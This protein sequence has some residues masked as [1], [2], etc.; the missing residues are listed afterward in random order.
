M[1]SLSAHIHIFLIL[2]R[3]ICLLLSV[4]VFFKWEFQGGMMNRRSVHHEGRLSPCEWICSVLQQIIT[5]R[6]CT[7][8]FPVVRLFSYQGGILQILNR[9]LDGT[10]GQRQICGYGLD[11]R[12]RFAFFVLSRGF[13]TTSNRVGRIYFTLLDRILLS[14][15]QAFCLLTYICSQDL[16]SVLLATGLFRVSSIPTLFS[17]ALSTV[18]K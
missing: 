11:S 9:S 17:L 15:R 1:L 12:P 16:P 3:D 10:A 13:R 5:I 4:I 2:I 6:G 7:A 18:S 14:S 8:V